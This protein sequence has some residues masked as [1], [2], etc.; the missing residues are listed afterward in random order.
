MFAGRDNELKRLNSLYESKKFECVVL[1]GRRRVG[2][3]T[4]LREFI[5][6]K[7]A[8]Y[9][10]SQ[11][12]CS[13]ENLRS[14]TRTIKNYK[15]D[16]SSQSWDSKDYIDTLEYL[17]RLARSE[18][19]VFI[20]DDYQFLT[21]SQK[22]ISEIICRQID[23]NLKYSR[24]M[25][26]ICGSSEPIMEKEVLSLDSV[27][28]GRRTAQI[29][30]K[31][32]LFKEVRQYYDNFTL[33]DSTIIYGL[34]GGVPKYLE[35]MSPDLPIEDNIRRAYFDTS[36][37]LFEEPSNI[38]RREV[39]D[40]TY[41]N[42]VLRAIAGG[43]NK[44]S[45]IAVAVGL[46]TAACT[47]YL[48]NL[49]A[50]NIVA[51]HTPTT[52]KIGKKTI[53]EIEDYLFRFWYRFIPDNISQIRLGMTSRIWRDIASNIPIY[54]GKV[55]EDISKQWLTDQNSL[56]LLQIRAVEFG[57]WW[58]IDPVS[59]E[60]TTMPIIAYADDDNAVFGDSIWSEE[61]VEATAL[62]SLLNR[63]RLFDFR[64]KHFYLFSCSGFTSECISLAQKYDASLIMFE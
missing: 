15:R 20:I 43:L 31:P 1:H 35:L 21:Q 57:R 59:K 42:A 61:P 64:N 22:N 5:K 48:K 13:I 45:E 25:L 28:Y 53:Y 3:T 37:F 62:Q 29:L 10:S 38:L 16:E 14:L 32:F 27:F 52:E 18:R 39:R 63:S 17:Y 44:N 56:G 47:A 51:K 19:I 6:D 58:G 23:Q 24:L 46:D 30:L 55:F 60:K 33:Y 9:F 50:M 11:E 34:T 49:I 4:L 12:T 8:I 7:K 2:K 36:S 40:P 54:M 41:Y 26:I